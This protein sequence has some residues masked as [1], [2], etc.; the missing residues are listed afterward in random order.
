[1][2]PRMDEPRDAVTVIARA[3]LRISFVGGGTDFPHWFDEHGGA[4]LST[5]ID[6]YAEV[7]LHPR[8]DE[9]ISI[10][11]IDF[12]HLVA[13]DVETGPVYDGVMDLPKAALAR[14]GVR[15]GLDVDIR[16]DAP[17][18]SGLGGSSALVTAVVAALAALDGRP[19]T[20]DDLA[21]RS[22][23]IER[24]D[25]GIAGGWQDQYATAFGGLNLLEFAT[26]GVD[27]TP[28]RVDRDVLERLG[29][30]LML[31][32]TG[33]VR[34]NVGLIDAQVRLHAEGREETIQGMK[35]L[36]AL[37][38]EMRDALEQGDVGAIGPMLQQAY[39]SKKRMNPH[40]AE[41]TPIEGL[42]AA[43]REAGASGGK[44]CGAGGGGYL[45]LACEPRRRESVRTALE[46]LGGRFVPFAFDPAGVRAHVSAR[47]WEP[48]R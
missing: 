4:V 41:G 21:R 8:D 39:E 1:M 35:Q 14:I 43:A 47:P 2:D 20:A 23:A 24:E 34:A 29:A 3:P 22:Y 12:G 17:P 19:M 18:G 33:R 36:Q 9:R 28:V 42:F 38:Y 25:L 48:A 40:I 44:I 46:A 7:T 16:A 31:C 11:S 45:L 10:R 30:S 26:Q 27:V 32:Y 37:A 5:T 15:R 13:Y 6:H